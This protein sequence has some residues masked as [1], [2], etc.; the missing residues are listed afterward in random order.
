MGFEATGR[1]TEAPVRR[2]IY[3]SELA[4]RSRWN[5]GSLN[6][7]DLTRW[8]VRENLATLDDDGLLRPTPLVFEL[9]LAVFD[10]D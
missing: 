9:D 7:V 10:D 2:G 1:S 4:A 8:L 5:S 3:P 6:A